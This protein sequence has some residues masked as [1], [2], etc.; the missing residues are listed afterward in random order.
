M[1]TPEE[2]AEAK[3]ILENIKFEVEIALREVDGRELP[4]EAIL[5]FIE[6]LGFHSALLDR[7][8]GQAF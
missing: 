1:F 8:V 2:L 4:D 5:A 7:I 3:E 6:N